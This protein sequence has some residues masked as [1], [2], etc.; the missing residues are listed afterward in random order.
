MPH[1]LEW[2]QAGIVAPRAVR[3][4]RRARLPR[5][6]RPRGVRR[7]RRRRLPL[8]PRHR[9]GDP[10][11][12]RRRRRARAHA[13]TTTSA[14]RTSSRY[15]TDEQKARW[16]PGICSGELIT[17]IA[18]TEPGIGSDLAS[19]TH[20]RDPRRRPLRRQRLEDV[21]HQRHQRRPRHHRGE[22][23]PDAS[24][25]RACA[26]SS[27]SG[28]WPGFER[29]RNL[30]K[31]GLHAQ[32]TAELFFTDVAVPVGNLL[33]EEGEGFLQLVAQP[34][35]G[36]ALDRRRRRRRGPRRRST[37]RSST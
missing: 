37:G 2:E 9:R 11:G 12:R 17:A 28:A 7:R 10:G 35:P 20:H 22:D 8:Q 30:E 29:G 33:G 24:A 13:C 23:R 25:T 15:C 19:M 4:G 26:C 27:S 16:L 1:H 34:A 3:R 32:D 21:H 31:I 5:H 18:M 36:A 14:C 6:G